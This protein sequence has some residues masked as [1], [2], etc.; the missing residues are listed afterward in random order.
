[1]LRQAEEMRKEIVANVRG[2][3]GQAE[4]VHILESSLDEFN[5]KGRVFAKITLPPGASVGWHQHVGD[6]EAY[7]VLSGEGMVNDNGTEVAVKTGDMVLTRDGQ[8]HSIAN[9]AADDLVFLGLILF[10]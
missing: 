8:Y 4:I 7:Y 1:M 2:G 5:G 9:T 3:E 10:A 6:S